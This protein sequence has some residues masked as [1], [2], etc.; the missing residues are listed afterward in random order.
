M[1][2]GE[3]V[4]VGTYS[5]SYDRY[6]GTLRSIVHILSILI[7]LFSTYAPAQMRANPYQWEIRSTTWTAQNEAT[8]GEFIARIGRARRERR[9]RTVSDCLNNPSI[10]MFLNAGNDGERFDW[11]ADCARLPYLLRAYF[12]WKNALPFS[13]ESNVGAVGNTRDIRYS[14]LGNEV[15]GR[16][17]LVSPQRGVLDA[18]A[19]IRTVMGNVS[20]A[21]FRIDPRRD[22]IRRF[23]D[24]VSPPIDR[25]HIRPGTNIYDPNG[26]VAVVFEVN[27]NGVI[28]YI[29]AHPD[30]SLTVGM[31][32]RKFANSGAAHG[33]GF[34]NWR[35][36]R[37]EEA[38]LSGESYRGGH[39]AAASNSE[40]ERLRDFSMI[41]TFGN[42]H[43]VVEQ[44]RAV[45]W[46]SN[47]FVANGSQMNFY[48]YLRFALNASGTSLRYRPLEEV[49][50]MIQGLCNDIQDRVGAVQDAVNAHID[51]AEHPDEFPRN[52]YGANGEWEAYSSPSRDARLKTSFKE[53]KDQSLRFIN[54]RRISSPLID[55]SGSVRQLIEGIATELNRV[56][57]QCDISYTKSNGQTQRLSFSEV[58]RRLFDMSFDPY[59]CAERRW[60][61][62]ESEELATCHDDRNDVA[63]Y[64]V[65]RRLRNQIDRT[66][67]AFMGYDLTAMNNPQTGGALGVETPPNIDLISA[68]QSQ[69]ELGFPL[70]HGN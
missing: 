68:L 12:A 45:S 56:E 4:M 19:A 1:T 39:I 69:E 25:N 50:N 26:H 35:P 7:L 22:S 61:A 65:E 9:C 60:G 6:F 5:K 58:A 44:S 46:E 14:P 64:Q 34:K 54:L 42:S 3:C 11:R 49:R 23:S 32:G 20:S 33:A 15:L 48:D 52:I 59:H 21:N 43:P 36:I 38:T 30:N 66:Y 40:L 29:D 47:N 8:Y 62:L 55:Y 51:R 18:R 17:D 41:Q 53:L 63:W 57:S 70:V 37:L 24:F 31:F 13:F 10:N 28:S 2:R 67:D 16:T 27:D